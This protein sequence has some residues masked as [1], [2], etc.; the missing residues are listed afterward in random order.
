MATIDHVSGTGTTGCLEPVNNE[1]VI[2]LKGALTRLPFNNISWQNLLTSSHITDPEDIERTRTAETDV[3]PEK[4][5]VA[6]EVD[7]CGAHSKID[8]LEIAL[9]MLWLMYFFN[10]LDRNALVNAK[11]NSLDKD[12]GLKGTQY[13]T[14]ISILFIR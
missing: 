14:L 9:T 11:L 4:L 5:A 3:A 12:L 1:K 6:T 10:F 13:N 8:P 7:E 2:L